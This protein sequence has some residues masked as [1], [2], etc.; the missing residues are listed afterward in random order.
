MSHD[1]N[2][3]GGTRRRN[4]VA[5]NPWR[6]GRRRPQAQEAGNRAEPAG[7]ARQRMA[8][9]MLAGLFADAS[10]AER[11][12]EALFQRG[13][14]QDDVVVVMA[15]TKW[16]KLFGSASGGGGAQ[17]L[18][19]GAPSASTQGSDR[20]SPATQHE[21]TPAP[22]AITSNFLT[23]RVMAAGRI[24]SL[25]ADASRPAHGDAL[26]RALVDCGIPER[27]AS[28]CAAGVAAGKILLGVVP[29]SADDAK[30]LGDEWSR[31]SG[32]VVGGR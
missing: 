12:H 13:Y 7:G 8:L 21:R 14:R 4:S 31:E 28:S 15:E 9:P 6:R 20:R 25:L 11:A 26:V 27:D 29:H 5:P 18:A 22:L 2:R 30:A 10:H 19:P 32:E 23:T 17:V 16:Q 3:A 1:S 24:A